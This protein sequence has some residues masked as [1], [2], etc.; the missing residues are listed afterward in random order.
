MSPGGSDSGR[1]RSREYAHVLRRQDTPVGVQHQGGEN[2]P[3]PVTGYDDR[4]GSRTNLKRPENRE[5][6]PQP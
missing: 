5:L 3:L 2:Q 6:Q 4:I 1:P